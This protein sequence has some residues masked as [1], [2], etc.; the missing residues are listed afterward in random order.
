M[1]EKRRNMSFLPLSTGGVGAKDRT[2]MELALIAVVMT[3]LAG[4]LEIARRVRTTAPRWVTR[5]S[6][7]YNYFRPA[8]A[9]RPRSRASGDADSAAEVLPVVLQSRA[10]PHH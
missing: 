3:V 1:A 9:T 4:G 6:L 10:A 2:M 8:D 7:R 5:A